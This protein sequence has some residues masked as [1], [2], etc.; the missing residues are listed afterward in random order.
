MSEAVPPVEKKKTTVTMHYES[1]VTCE[2]PSE[3]ETRITQHEFDMLCEGDPGKAEAKRD[4]AK[5]LFFAALIGL[6]SLG[7]TDWNTSLR[8]RPLPFYLFAI[9]F[10]LGLAWFGN[11]WHTFSKEV[12]QKQNDSVYS[13]T[14]IGIKTRL[15]AAAAAA[16]SASI[17]IE[18]NKSQEVQAGGSAV[19]AKDA[20]S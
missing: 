13:R 15:E 9:A 11:A 8:Q 20:A 18:S 3:V 12:K 5:N 4:N 10:L 1:V 19:P 16:N 7:A 14:K 6:A 2:R 17:Q